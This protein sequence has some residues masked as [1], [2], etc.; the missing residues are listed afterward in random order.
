[1][2]ASGA[3][4]PLRR[5]DRASLDDRVRAHGGPHPAAGAVYARNSLQSTTRHTHTVHGHH[6]PYT[7]PLATPYTMSCLTLTGVIDGPLPGGEPKA[8][9]L[10]VSCDIE[11]LSAYGLGSAN[12]GGTRIGESTRLPIA[13]S[14]S[15]LEFEFPDDEADAGDFIYVIN[16]SDNGAANFEAFL[17]FEADYEDSALA[18]NGDDVVELYFNGVVVDQFGRGGY[19]VLRRRCGALLSV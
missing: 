1:M 17:G 19:V 15:A 18:I 9:E 10:Y 13:R 3:P 14:D 12:N 11:D 2:F 16:D 4:N 6:P 5:S 8:V 7:H